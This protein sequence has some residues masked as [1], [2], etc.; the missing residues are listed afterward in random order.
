MGRV[1]QFRGIG[2]LT[3][4]ALAFT[5]LVVPAANATARSPFDS[6]GLPVGY[7]CYKDGAQHQ[8]SCFTPKARVPPDLRCY[9]HGD[10]Y[11]CY[12]PSAA[13]TRRAQLPPLTCSMDHPDSYICYD[14][15]SVPSPPPPPQQVTVTPPRH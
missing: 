4:A 7:R 5:G 6:R 14:A 8:W 9:A 3:V 13:V 15:T 11:E 1:S 2:A 12:R 10:S